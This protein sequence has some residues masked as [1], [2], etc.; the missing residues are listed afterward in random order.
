MRR[1][2][3]ER[4]RKSGKNAASPSQCFSMPFCGLCE[5]V[6]NLAGQQTWGPD[7]LL[8]WKT[9]K[10]FL[11][12]SLSFFISFSLAQLAGW[13]TSEGPGSG[14]SFRAIALV[15]SAHIEESDSTYGPALGRFR[16]VKGKASRTRIHDYRSFRDFRALWPMFDASPIKMYEV[17]C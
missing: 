2:K 15:L 8:T 11:S 17:F 7:L 4:K 16:S 5:R 1:Y 14:K 12:L 9:V 3:V 6:Q 13:H 10:A